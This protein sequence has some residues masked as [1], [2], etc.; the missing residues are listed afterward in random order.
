MEFA[1]SVSVGFGPSEVEIHLIFN[2]EYPL[3]REANIMMRKAV[4]A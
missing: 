1:T 3:K 4:A 2:E